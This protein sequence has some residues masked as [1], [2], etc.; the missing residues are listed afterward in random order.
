MLELRRKQ[1]ESALRKQQKPA[2][3][4]VKLLAALGLWASP[5]ECNTPGTP[6][7]PTTALAESLGWRCRLQMLDLNDNSICDGGAEAVAQ[8]LKQNLQSLQDLVLQNNEICDRGAQALADSLQ[9]H[10][11][12]Q[13]LHLG[14]NSIG[15]RGAQALVFT[16]RF[17]RRLYL[18]GNFLGDQGAEAIARILLFNEGLTELRVSGFLRSTAGGQALHA[19]ESKVNQRRGLFDKFQI[20]WS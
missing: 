15:D 14:A 10:R 18:E 12:L 19:A 3:M 6:A 20:V 4:A 2:A 8:S 11:N 17:L 5:A 9:S 16:S 7:A 1:L 13:S